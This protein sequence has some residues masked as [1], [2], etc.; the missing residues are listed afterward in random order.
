LT[1]K[2]TL[3]DGY[4]MR[5]LG[6]LILIALATAAPAVVRAQDRGV[7]LGALAGEPTGITAKFWETPD[8]ALDF[9]AAWS[10]VDDGIFQLHADWL[11]SAFGL[12]EAQNGKVPLYLGFGFRFEF[13]DIDQ[14]SND[15]QFAVRFPLGIDFMSRRRRVDFFAEIVPIL[16][17]TPETAFDLDG[18]VGVRYW[19]RQGL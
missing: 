6:C 3:V 8:S 2:G 19:F 4:G 10:L 5:R 17:L 7:G 18:G 1:T 14:T 9:A 13:V 16:E 15:T 12:L 11:W